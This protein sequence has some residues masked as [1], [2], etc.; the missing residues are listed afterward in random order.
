MSTT[1]LSAAATSSFATETE[2]YLTSDG[3]VIIAD[4][5]AELVELVSLLGEVEACEI[6]SLAPAL[7]ESWKAGR[8]EHGQKEERSR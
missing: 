1:N 6:A 7:E 8:E 5:P 3:R 4:L 2:I